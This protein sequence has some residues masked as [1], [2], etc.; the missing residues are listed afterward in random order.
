MKRLAVVAGVVLAL[1]ASAASA[2]EL[3]RGANI[4]MSIEQVVATVPEAHAAE[5]ETRGGLDLG[6]AVDA[7]TIGRD[8]W[9]ANFFFK[10]GR[11]EMVLLMPSEEVSALAYGPMFNPLLDDLRE[12]Y[13]E[14]FSCDAGQ[15]GRDCEWRFPD[16]TIT[17]SHA[18]IY[19][20]KSLHIR[21]EK[22]EDAKPPL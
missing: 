22:R 11:L 8:T 6:A 19:S 7:I 1:C 12:A 17:L 14:P 21:Y 10:D 2:Q 13:G 9:S 4:D 5:G 15:F 18:D 16:R 3:W 20:V